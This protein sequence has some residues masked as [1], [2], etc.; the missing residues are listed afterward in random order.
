MAGDGDQSYRFPSPDLADDTASS[1]HSGCDPYTS[2]TRPGADKPP[3][4][5]GL[6]PR[7]RQ[8]APISLLWSKEPVVLDSVMVDNGDNVFVWS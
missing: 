6:I 7:P 3:A 8:F 2:N 1:R 4:R 5:I